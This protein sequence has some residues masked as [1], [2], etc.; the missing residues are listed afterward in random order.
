MD[1]GIKGGRS[2]IQRMK[3][4][5]VSLYLYKIDMNES[6]EYWV[7]SFILLIIIILLVSMTYEDLFTR[8]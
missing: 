1:E 5:S 2:Q 4:E 6:K 3:I 8:S 7:T